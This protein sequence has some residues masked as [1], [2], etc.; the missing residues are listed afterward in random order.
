M[1]GV[2]LKVVAVDGGQTREFPL[3]TRMRSGGAG[4]WM[5]DGSGLIF[6]GNEEGRYGVF[7]L[8]FESGNVD[9]LMS[10]G[11]LDVLAGRFRFDLTP[12]GQSMVYVEDMFGAAQELSR[13]VV[14]SL[15]S[16]FERTLVTGSGGS[17]PNVPPRVSPDGMWVAFYRFGVDGVGGAGPQG[18]VYDLMLV[19]LAGG[20]PRRIASTNGGFTWASDSKALLFG[21]PEIRRIPIDGGP[22]VGLG[23]RGGVV[24]VD[25]AGR[26]MTYSVP[27]GGGPDQLWLMGTGAVP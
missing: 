7:R 15:A 23:I 19:P 4:R 22:P 2:L 18:Q 27:E 11:G 17:G 1:G 10:G 13:L 24:W 5:R 14:R 3:P 26:T 16:G 20:E 21:G 6:V 25:P 8:D 12:D 9:R